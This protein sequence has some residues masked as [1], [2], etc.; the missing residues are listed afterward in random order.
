MKN[1]KKNLSIRKNIDPFVEITKT[2]E[3]E[4]WDTKSRFKIR[5]AEEV[6]RMR[7]LNNLSQVELARLAGTTQRIISSIENAEMTP[8]SFLL[9][10]IVTA[11]NASSQELGKM[12]DR[13]QSYIVINSSS[14]NSKIESKSNEVMLDIRANY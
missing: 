8:G 9:F 6:Y 10:K 4:E 12:Y 3:F 13:P 14:Y 2:E 7:E 11:L 1:S 5:I